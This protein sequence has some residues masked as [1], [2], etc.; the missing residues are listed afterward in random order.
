L[1][2]ASDVSKDAS[3]WQKVISNGLTTRIKNDSGLM[4]IISIAAVCCC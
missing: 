1:A 4:N 2:P 3:S